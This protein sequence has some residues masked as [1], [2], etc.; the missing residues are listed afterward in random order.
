MAGL[1]EYEAEA[2]SEAYDAESPRFEEVVG[3]RLAKKMASDV[4]KAHAEE[5]EE[6]EEVD[7]DTHFKRK[8]K[9]S[10]SCKPPQKKQVVS[11][12]CQHTQEVSS[13]G[14]DE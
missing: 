12:P 10:S 11:K 7:P 1:P 8:R 13:T 3:G 5:D 9:G 6:K 4:D 14:E 2:G